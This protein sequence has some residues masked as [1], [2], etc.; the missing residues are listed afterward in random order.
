MKRLLCYAAALLLPITLRAQAVTPAV[1]DSVRTAH[2]TPGLQTLDAKNG[3]RDIKLGSPRAAIKGLVQS[4]APDNGI[5]FYQRPTDAKK[6][7]PYDLASITYMFYQDKLLAVFLQVEGKSNITGVMETLQ[8]LYG[9]STDAQEHDYKVNSIPQ[10]WMGKQVAL[11][12]VQGINPDGASVF[13]FSKPLLQIVDA[14][15]KK[16]QQRAIN[17]L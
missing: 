16:A 3:F 17:D 10:K 4:E 15:Q 11:K 1:P 2:Y 9:P 8:K 14:D 5:T 6:I 7:G 13:F 12:V